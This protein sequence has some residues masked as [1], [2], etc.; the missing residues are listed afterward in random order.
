MGSVFRLGVIAVAFALLLVCVLDISAAQTSGIINHGP[1]DVNKV[2]ISF[3]DGP[4]HSF[5]AELL[6]ILQENHVHA[7]F[8]VV[9]E[10]V[11][12]SPDAVHRILAEGHTLGNHS[13]D[14]PNLT[15]IPPEKL[16]TELDHQIGDTNH[17]VMELTEKRMNLFRTPYGAINNEI[18]ADINAKGFSIIHWDVDTRDWDKSITADK[19]VETV[20]EQ[21]QPGS[22]ILMHSAPWIN[23]D[24]LQAIQEIIDYVRS[25]NLELV[26]IDE[27]LSIQ[28]YGE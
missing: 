10:M 18:I 5:T 8:F 21:I 14:H 28:A 20:K 22:I 24:R 4:D 23:K 7:T 6:D 26:T 9:G 25:K 13:F 19:I 3:D 12:K 11:K 15:Q 2:A 17:L 16:E 27:L 1:R